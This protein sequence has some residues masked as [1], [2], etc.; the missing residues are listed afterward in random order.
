MGDSVTRVSAEFVTHEGFSK[1]R[2][3]VTAKSM[4]AEYRTGRREGLL[5]WIDNEEA[6]RVHRD[7]QRCEFVLRSES[8]S[9]MPLPL[10]QQFRQSSST[11]NLVVINL[12][13]Y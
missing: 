4:L 6:R 8:S 9:G 12:A 3:H 5:E 2:A 13:V 10:C 1:G 7:G 11:R